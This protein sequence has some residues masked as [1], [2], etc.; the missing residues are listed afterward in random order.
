ML[1]DIITVVFDQEVY[2]LEW[3]AKSIQ[4]FLDPDEINEIILV[5]N[6]S[7]KC[8]PDLDWYGALKNKV[9]II[10]H[11]HLGL[12]VMPHLD[13]WRTQ[14]LC[15]IL[16]AARSKCEYSLIL[17][18]KT[19]FAKDIRIHNFFYNNRPA[20]GTIPTSDHWKDSKE[21]LEKYFAIEIKDVI[22]PGGVP[23]FF[24]TETIN[25][26]IKHIQ[27]FNTWFQDNLYE[28]T[29][30]HRT[31]VT[32]FMLYSAFVL[33]KHGQYDS[34]YSTKKTISPFNVADWEAEKFENIFTTDAHTISVAEKTKNFLTQEQ[35]SRWEA[36]L[37]DK[38]N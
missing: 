28:Q 31:K 21:Y 20:V 24:H 33:H 35:L 6:G 2:L 26:M 25:E 37:N 38:Y 1:V 14:Q 27:D 5:D 8:E 4:K 19:L 17:D 23:Y 7:Q 10:N 22:G 29:Y 30:P 12:K 9:R 36:F 32:E 15:K 13:G 16:A 18:A 11:S 3:Q 34:L